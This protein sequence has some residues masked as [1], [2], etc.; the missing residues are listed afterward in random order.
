MIE[1]VFDSKKIDKKY[2]ETLRDRL[3]NMAWDMVVSGDSLH[4]KEALIR[5][6]KETNSIRKMMIQRK[7]LILQGKKGRV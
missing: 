1:M 6:V 5:L 3:E 2:L 4:F 7:I